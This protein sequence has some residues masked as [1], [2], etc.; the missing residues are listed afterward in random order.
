VCTN[1]VRAPTATNQNEQRVG[2]HL[3]QDLRSLSSVRM[4]MCVTDLTRDSD[5]SV[6]A[7]WL[8]PCVE[9]SAA[10]CRSHGSPCHLSVK[11]SSVTTKHRSRDPRGASADSTRVRRSRVPAV[12]CGCATAP[13]NALHCTRR[14]AQAAASHQLV[15]SLAF[16]HRL[17]LAHARLPAHTDSRNH[18]ITVEVSPMPHGHARID[19]S[20]DE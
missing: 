14:D 12:A 15:C 10:L 9:V 2:V 16:A 7:L 17:R 8:C 5:T 19:A 6:S 4:S 18:A 3:V 20:A 13:R 1:A 11:A